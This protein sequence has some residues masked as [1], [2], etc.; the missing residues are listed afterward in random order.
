MG[1]IG[2]NR[3]VEEAQF[4]KEQAIAWAADES[5]WPTR[6]FQLQ[7]Q[8]AGNS[9]LVTETM[10]QVLQRQRGGTLVELIPK[11]RKAAGLPPRRENKY[12]RLPECP[13]CKAPRG[14]PCTKGGA[15][16]KTRTHKPREAAAIDEAAGE[17][18]STGT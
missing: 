7:T 12:D 11:N 9:R 4:T 13:T 6:R 15:G 2:H 14:K 17:R 16:T 10:G 1:V 8:V 18:E 3:C 5:R